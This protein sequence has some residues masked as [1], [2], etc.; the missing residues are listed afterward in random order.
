MGDGGD[1]VVF[2]DVEAVLGEERA[3][4]GD[5]ADEGDEGGGG[6]GGGDAVG[7]FL[8]GYAGFGKRGGAIVA[9]REEGE[10][11]EEGDG[12]QDEGAL[13][14]EGRAFLVGVGLG[15]PS[16]KSMADGS[17]GS[18]GIVSNGYVKRDGLC[19][20]SRP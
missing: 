2:L 9:Q 10:D 8:A 20:P 15:H 6:D 18:H 14:E 16:G 3:A 17:P 12:E 11:A 5:E 19:R 13:E 1:E 7:G 4:G